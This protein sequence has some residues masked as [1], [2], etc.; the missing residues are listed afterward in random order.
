M[1]TNTELLIGL[2]IGTSGCKASVVDLTG[3]IIESSTH[4]YQTDYPRPGLAE[5][6]PED[7]YYSA[8]MAVRSCIA[9]G[10]FPP[11]DIVGIGITGPAHNVALM[12]DTGKVLRP[13]IHWSDLRSASQCEY[14]D[15]KMSEEIFKIT[16]QRVNP[17][18]T[19]PQLMWL[20]EKETDIWKK[21]QHILV[22]KDYVRYRLNG[23][24]HT[25][26]YDAIGTQMFNVAESKWSQY[27][28]DFLEFNIDWLPQVLPATEISGRLT[29]CGAEDTGLSEGTPIVIGSGDSVVEA[30]G[31]G[32]TEIGQC[33]IKLGSAANVDLVTKAP[34]PSLETMTYHHIVDDRWFS[35]AATNSGSSTL[36]WFRNTFCQLQV[37]KAKEQN[38]D[39]YELIGNLA[40]NVTPGCE[41]LLF[42]PYLMGERT[43]YW[44]PYLRGDFV[45]ITAHH[46][47]HHF[48][49]AILEGVAF[50]IRDCY[51][52]ITSLG[53]TV[54]ER[55]LIGGGSKSLLWSQILCDVL[56][57][58]LLKPVIN[59]A[60]YGAALLAGIGVGLFENYQDATK[61]CVKIT[62][63]LSPNFEFHNLYNKYF[64]IYKEIVHQLADQDYKLIEL[65]R[66]SKKLSNER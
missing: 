36:R 47:L 49:R 33:L 57:E 13:T 11:R 2:D 48:T 17:S 12:D 22:T 61:Q 51:Q 21:L 35:I 44:N 52:E 40:E 32:I 45:G 50:S 28:C 31:I 14:L 43:P 66:I 37:L 63:E 64:S 46:K 23:K 55:R 8:C 19:L 62:E 24:Y 7:W 26:L 10:K 56:G 20:K 54:T 29:H 59:D 34:L 41:G 4:V 38:L 5:Q 42:H 65:D 58:P 27:L 1:R 9:T 16:Y 30:F 3:S 18:W 39:P 25:D 6:N 53:Q 15:S 60:A